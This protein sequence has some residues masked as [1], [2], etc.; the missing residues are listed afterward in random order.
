[1]ARQGPK[2]GRHDGSQCLPLARLH[3][4]DGAIIQGERGEDLHVERTQ[5]KDAP[6]RLARK[7][8]ERCSNGPGRGPGPRT[9]LRAS[10][11]LGTAK[12]C[13]NLDAKLTRTSLELLVGALTDFVLAAIDLGHRLIVG[14]QVKRDRRA[15]KMNETLT[16]PDGVPHT[17]MLAAGY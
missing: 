7:R 6:G 10:A 2:R 15:L 9:R 8:E 4:D 5:A 16:P 14:A 1:M 12:S 11:W 13:L 3:F 17:V